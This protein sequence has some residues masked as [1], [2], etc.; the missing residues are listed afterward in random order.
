MTRLMLATTTSSVCETCCDGG[1]AE[2][3]A[4]FD[5]GDG[6]TSPVALTHSIPS[7]AW[8]FSAGQ[9]V[10][11][12]DAA[13]AGWSVPHTAETGPLVYKVRA[14]VRGEGFV[15]DNDGGVFIESTT[16]AWRVDF[17]IESGNLLIRWTDLDAVTR[18]AYFSLPASPGEM[19]L[20]VVPI[21]STIA[22]IKGSVDNVQHVLSVGMAA[23]PSEPYP[24][25]TMGVWRPASADTGVADPCCPSYNRRE[26][27]TVDHNEALSNGTTLTV[28]GVLT[29]DEIAEKFVGNVTVTDNSCSETLIL[30]W[31]IHCDGTNYI[32]TLPAPYAATYTGTIDC[33]A[34]VLTF[35]TFESPTN[36]S[37]GISPKAFAL[38]FTGAAG[39]G[40]PV[41]EFD[42]VAMSYCGTNN[43]AC[44]TK[45]GCP[46]LCP[47]GVIPCVTA[48]VYCAADSQWHAYPMPFADFI[49][50]LGHQSCGWVGEVCTWGA[51]Y[52]HPFYAGEAQAYLQ[53][54]SFGQEDDTQWVKTGETGCL[55]PYGEYVRVSNVD[56]IHIVP[57]CYET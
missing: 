1:C 31:T 43:D 49:G 16:P 37:D 11:S 53:T 50:A 52:L 19:V 33:N 51:I 12:A 21:C 4:T 26:S 28:Q 27:F 40:G 15:G 2:N 18:T 46:E 32:L 36:C 5:S 30:E 7:P 41:R 47:D 44:P 54:R 13:D 38:E 20:E 14:D 29:W 6:V 39:S 57:G 35:A 24:N 23:I 48:L 3:T 42:N 56:V 8:S 10:A 45:R 17:G 22:T 9:L 25:V 55:S 34:G